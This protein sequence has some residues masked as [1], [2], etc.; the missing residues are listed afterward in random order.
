M[1]QGLHRYH[2]NRQQV[3]LAHLFKKPPLGRFFCGECVISKT[4]NTGEEALSVLGQRWQLPVQGEAWRAGAALAQSTG[5]PGVVAQVLAAR[6][7]GELALATTFLNPRLEQLPD[8]STLKDLDTAAAH[9]AEAIRQKRSIAIFGDYDVDGTCATA[10]LTRYLRQLGTNP[11]LYIPDRLTEGYGPTPEAMRKL[12][13]QGA[14]LLITVDTGT[15]AHA[16]LEEAR[17]L[18]LEVIVT[19]HHQQEATLPPAIAILNPQRADD[20]SALQS[21]SGSGVAFYLVMGLN[22]LLRTQGFFATHPEPRLTDLLDLVALATVAD[23]MPLTGLNRVLVAR[24]LQQLGTWRHRGLAALAGVAGV[25]DDVSATSLGFS[26]APRLNAAGRIDSAQAALNLLLAEDEAQALPLA[27]TLNTLNQQRQQLEKS[28]LQQALQQ[29][30]AQMED[31]HT[32]ALVLSG[33]GWHPGVAGI[34]AARVKERFNRPTFILGLDANGQL[35]GSGRSIT[36]LNLGQA[37]HACKTLLASGGGHAMAAGV[38]L[39]ATNLEAFRTALNQAL[40]QQLE[41]RVE[42][43]HLPLTHR[44]APTLTLETTCTAPGLTAELASSLQQLAPFGMGNAEPL[45]ALMQTRVAY[46]KPVG[47]TQEHLKLTLTDALGTAKLDAICFGAMNSALGPTLSN[48]GGK[49]LALA[50]TARPRIFNGKQ[51]LEVQVKDAH[52]APPNKS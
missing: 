13:E 14:Q 6:G 48:T 22:R 29:A 9:L 40:W 11:I 42:D 12:K 1:E 39:E 10:L 52:L 45:I 27:Q 49:P 32:L 44:L 50:V 51:L 41:A 38:T 24:G 7:Y 28:I 5:L 15:T 25:R 2:H 17:K 36:G 26:L 31:P 46:A 18:G 19:D 37:V 43:A 8:P 34:V 4:M 23:V 33:E 35:K 20:T 30:E 3:K 16:A 21:L 47:A